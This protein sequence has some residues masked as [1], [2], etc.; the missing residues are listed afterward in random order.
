MGQK[1][2]QEETMLQSKQSRIMQTFFRDRGERVIPKVLGRIIRRR[3]R[4]SGVARSK[5]PAFCIIRCVHRSEMNGGFGV[6]VNDDDVD[7]D[8]DGDD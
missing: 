4:V 2:K 1:G 3:P 8:G 5:E 6:V 7:D